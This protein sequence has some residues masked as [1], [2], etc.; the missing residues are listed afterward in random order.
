M[1]G[2]TR[3]VD[4]LLEENFI[5]QSSLSNL[6]TYTFILTLDTHECIN[7]IFVRQEASCKISENLHLMKIFHFTVCTCM[8]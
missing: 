6:P 2:Y 8:K 1:A 5:R 3:I 7:D 4:F